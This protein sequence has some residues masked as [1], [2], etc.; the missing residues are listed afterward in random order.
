MKNDSYVSF[1]IS[2]TKFLPYQN[3]I[4]IEGERERKLINYELTK[5]ISN[6]ENLSQSPSLVIKVDSPTFLISHNILNCRDGR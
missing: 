1:F 3:Y 6:I 2:L 5:F 4:F